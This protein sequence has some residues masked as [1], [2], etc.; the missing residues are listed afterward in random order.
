MSDSDTYFWINDIAAWAS[1]DGA[2]TVHPLWTKEK[3]PGSGWWITTGVENSCPWDLAISE[4][5]PNVIYQAYWDMGLWRSLDHGQYWQSCNNTDLTGAWTK[6]VKPPSKQGIG[7]NSR[8]V[9][10]DPARAN[11]VWASIGGDQTDPQKVYKSSNYGQFDSWVATTGLPSTYVI[12]G[13]SVDNNSD[14]ANRTLFVTALGNI[15][16]SVNDGMTWSIVSNGLNCQ[17]TMTDRFDSSYV[18]AGGTGGFYRSTDAGGT[19]SETGLPEMTSVF[20]IK[21]DPSNPTWIYVACCG[22]NK[23]LYLS[24][25]KG[26]NWTKILT[27]DFLRGVAVDP[28]NPLNIYTASSSAVS[29]G[30]YKEKSTGIKYTRNGG[31]TWISANE[32]VSWPFAYCVEV[33]PNDNSFVFAGMPGMNFKKRQFS[34][35]LVS[36]DANKKSEKYPKLL[37]YPNPVKQAFTI[38]LPHPGDYN[39]VINDISGR[40]VYERTKITEQHIVDCRVFPGGI[41]IVKVSDKR[42]VLIGKFIKE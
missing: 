27:D 34:D 20:D 2:R 4:A 13:L 21:T 31:T 38:K 30:G 24:K 9:C 14:P 5:D 1:F 32:G 11:V 18:Y 28:K 26:S 40:K 12:N 25:D 15:Y 10:A 36:S 41:Y 33:D 37:I 8:T 35:I 6:S 23:G 17:Y 3:T 22:T 19:W 16:K 7:G 39:L 42:Y 29:S